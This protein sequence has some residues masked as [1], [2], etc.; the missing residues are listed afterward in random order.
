MIS[1]DNQMEAFESM[2]QMVRLE[3]ETS[4]HIRNKSK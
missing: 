3:K 2:E 4:G 1:Y